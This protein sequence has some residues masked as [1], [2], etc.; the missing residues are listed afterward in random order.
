MKEK[1]LFSFLFNISASLSPLTRTTFRTHQETV[2]DVF[3]QE[4]Q[5][6]VR[7]ARVPLLRSETT[8]MVGYDFG[9]MYI[10]QRAKAWNFLQDWADVH[11]PDSRG[12]VWA[13]ACTSH[14]NNPLKSSPF[15]SLAPFFFNLFFLQPMLFTALSQQAEGKSW[16][17]QDSESGKSVSSQS[18]MSRIVSTIVRISL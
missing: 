3:I 14:I 18:L 7:G 17:N 8:Q 16:R 11:T 9:E 5:D 10:L 12:G 15:I 2:C 13:R 6:S 1:S 4:N